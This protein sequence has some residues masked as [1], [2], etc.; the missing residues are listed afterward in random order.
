MP[1][2]CSICQKTYAENVEI[3]EID[4]MKKKKE[5]EKS[6]GLAIWRGNTNQVDAMLDY[7]ATATKPNYTQLLLGFLEFG[8]KEEQYKKLRLIMEKQYDLVPLDT[9]VFQYM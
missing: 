9:I 5:F 7:A 2:R 4:M 3:E 6:T 1:P 8:A